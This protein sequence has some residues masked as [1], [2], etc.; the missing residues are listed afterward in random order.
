MD[1]IRNMARSAGFAL[2][3][4][5]VGLAHASPTVPATW[6]LSGVRFDDGTAVSGQFTYD[7]ASDNLLSYSISVVDGSL[8]GLNYNAADSFLYE[9][10][11]VGYWAANELAIAANDGSSYIVLN[12]AA[13]LSNAGGIVS[14]L[15]DSSNLTTASWQSNVDGSVTRYVVQGAITSPAATA[16]E[17]ASLPLVLFGFAGLAL[18]PAI[19][20]RRT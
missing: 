8:P 14:L 17:P 10:I 3:T 12:L 5:V 1:F 13:A 4:G 6:T 11:G 19:Q 9:P 15:T 7:A 2:L 16:A 20:R 18:M